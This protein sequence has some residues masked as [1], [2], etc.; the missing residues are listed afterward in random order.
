VL[1]V[2]SSQLTEQVAGAPDAQQHLGPLGGDRHDL[3]ASLGD[4]HQEAARITHA[5]HRATLA[6]PGLPSR[7]A[8]L[9]SGRLVEALHE[10]TA[11]GLVAHAASLPGVV[12]T[13]GT[14]PLCQLTQPATVRRRTVAGGTGSV[15]GPAVLEQ[16]GSAMV[17]RLK[18]EPALL[19]G[20]VQ[21]AL[22]VGVSFGLSLSPEQMAAVVALCAAAAAGLVRQRVSPVSTQDAVVP[23]AG[24]I[25]VQPVPDLAAAA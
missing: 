10:P 9:R 14:S 18:N 13:T 6:V 4:E 12:V 23:D 16:G 7:A 20:L 25:P 19:I 21:A 8:Q 5:E 1:I 2:E 24:V 11:R 15:G 22:A 17:T 3:R